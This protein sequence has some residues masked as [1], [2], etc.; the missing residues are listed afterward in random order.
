MWMKIIDEE[1]LALK[2]GVKSYL[3]LRKRKDYLKWMIN[4]RERLLQFKNIHQGEDCFI[5]GN[6]PSL[7]KMDL[8]LLNDYYTIGMNKIFLIF[9]KTKIDLSYLVAVN[10]LVIEQSIEE[11]KKFNIP[12]FLAYNTYSPDLERSNIYWLYT[13]KPWAF[14]GQITEGISVGGTVTF[15]ALQ[16]AYY[17]GFKRIFL[18]GVDHNFVQKGQP[19]ETQTMECNDENH[20]HPDYFKG[21]KWQ[22][23]DLDASEIS[24]KL[25]KRFCSLN[26]IEIFDATVD[27]NLNIF[28]KIDI[29]NVY[30]IARK[31]N[32]S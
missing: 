28:K 8:S 19:N 15:V 11:F 12:L 7:N 9:E 3:E 24:Y 31:R 29:K 16:L 20:F 17:L 14:Y 25:A 2:I 4:E 13:K 10:E 18:I 32:P 30:N 27:G 26:N 22:L 5:I 6:G 23:A 1:Y 21:N